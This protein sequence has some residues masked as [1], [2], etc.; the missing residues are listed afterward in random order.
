MRHLLPEIAAGACLAD[1][2]DD[3]L[4]GAD[5]LVVMTDWP[6]FAEADPAELLRR[7]RRPLVIDCVGVLNGSRE[8]LQGIEYVAMGSAG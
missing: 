6:T 1:S 8:R 3:A 2:R 4:N 5:C 7:M